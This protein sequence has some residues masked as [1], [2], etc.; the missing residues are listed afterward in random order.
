MRVAGGQQ[1][2]WVARLNP[3]PALPH[4]TSGTAAQAGGVPFGTSFRRTTFQA[5]PV[6]SIAR[7]HQ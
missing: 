3:Q 5:R 1:L 4:P 7:M 2:V 6:F